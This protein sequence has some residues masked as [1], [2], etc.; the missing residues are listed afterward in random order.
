MNMILLGPPG[1]GKGT[2]SNIISERFSA[3]QIS[4]GDILRQHVKD[5]TELGSEAKSYMDKG[6]LVPDDL[7]VSMV[8]ERIKNED[9][10]GG[11]ILDGFPRNV[12]QAKALEAM[13]MV[14]GKGI[15]SVIGIEVPSEELLKRLSGRRVCSVCG[16]AFHVDFN[17]PSADGTCDKCGGALY[18]RDDDKEDTIVERL[19]VYE[20]QTL[21]LIEFYTARGIFTGI[22]GTGEMSEITGR[23][24]SAIGR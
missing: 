22:G 18:Q 6:E 10:D 14:E 13:L 24:V 16:A 4:T 12:P 17:K 11:F 8:S 15:D 5:G 7:V 9:C 20:E 1:A 23:I 19:R 2:Q 3:P 21:P